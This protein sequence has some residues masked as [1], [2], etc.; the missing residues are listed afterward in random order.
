MFHHV[1][2]IDD[3]GRGLGK[4]VELPGFGHHIGGGISA[5]IDID[6]SGQPG[7]ATSEIVLQHVQPPS[8]IWSRA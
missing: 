8:T 3:F 6:E 7:I 4:H 5:D 1:P 2:G